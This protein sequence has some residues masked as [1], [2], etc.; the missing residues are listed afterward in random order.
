MI[1]L[2]HRNEVLLWWLSQ[3]RMACWYNTMLSPCPIQSNSRICLL[4]INADDI[5]GWTSSATDLSLDVGAAV[6]IIS[7][8]DKYYSGFVSIPV[9][10]LMVV[11][12]V[13]TTAVVGGGAAVVT[14]RVAG[15]RFLQQWYSPIPIQQ[16]IHTG[17]RICRNKTPT[18]PMIESII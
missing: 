7:N 16:T 2:S 4:C 9:S 10:L 15:C 3:N 14:T 13:D 17:I 8:Q 18:P 5:S 12:V 1:F 11:V 6:S